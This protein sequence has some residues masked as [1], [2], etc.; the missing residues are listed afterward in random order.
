MKLPTNNAGYEGRALAW[1]ILVAL[2]VLNLLRGSIHVFAADGGA[3]RIAGIDLSQNGDVIVALFAV[4][5][6]GQLAAGLIELFVGL[7]YRVLV[8]LM[9]AVEVLRLS[10]GVFVIW[11]YKPFPVDAPGKFGAPVILALLLFALVAS[12]SSHES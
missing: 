1:Q 11:F 4:W 3:G 9:L 10:L 6:S 7:R 8:P 5:G 12:R 2:G